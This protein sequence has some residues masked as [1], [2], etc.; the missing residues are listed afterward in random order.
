M[1]IAGRSI[2]LKI[3]NSCARFLPASTDAILHLAGCSGLVEREPSLQAINAGVRHKVATEMDAR[4][5]AAGQI[6]ARKRRIDMPELTIFTAPKPFTNP[7]IALMQRNAITSWLNLGPQVEVLLMG[8]ET[9]MTE[10]RPGMG[11]KHLPDVERNSNGTPLVSS[12]FAL[13]RQHSTS[14]LLACVN[15]DIVLMPD[16]VR[17]RWRGTSGASISDGGSALGSGGPRAAGICA[18]L[19]CA[20]A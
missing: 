18:R 17:S 5:R 11:V 2:P 14:P 8:D 15:A 6:P 16:V 3:W 12:M 13:A 7:H 10:I 1:L 4:M 9:G 20:P 19:A